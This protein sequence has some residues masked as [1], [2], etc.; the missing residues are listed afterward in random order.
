LAYST[1]HGITIACFCIKDYDPYFTS[2]I[3]RQ[4]YK[5]GKDDV[6]ALKDSGGGFGSSGS[7]GDQETEFRGDVKGKALPESEVHHKETVQV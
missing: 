3:P 1:D 2:H 4:I 5:G 6:G 7:E